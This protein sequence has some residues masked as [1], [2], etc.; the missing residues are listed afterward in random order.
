MVAINPYRG[1]ASSLDAL[2]SVVA[3]RKCRSL[4]GAGTLDEAVELWRPRPACP[5][6][7]FPD[8]TR[9]GKTPAGHQRWR[10]PVCGAAFSALVGTV[11]GIG[12]KEPGTTT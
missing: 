11:L 4:V 2:C 7:A 5:F 8:C 9:D 10:C 6:C 12:K 1:M 3:A